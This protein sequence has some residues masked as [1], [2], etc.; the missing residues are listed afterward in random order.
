MKRRLIGGCAISVFVAL[1]MGGGCTEPPLGWPGAGRQQNLPEPANDASLGD[2]EGGIANLPGSCIPK[3]VIC[4]VDTDCCDE[5]CTDSACGGLN[6]SSTP[7]C[8]TNGVVCEDSSD[9]CDGYCGAG[10][11]GNTPS[12]VCVPEFIM[13]MT[14]AECCNTPQIKCMNGACCGDLKNCT[15]DTT[16][17]QCVPYGVT[18]DNSSEC[19]T[20]QCSLNTSLQLVCDIPP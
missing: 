5:P 15:T 14:N 17:P 10:V 1:V 7:F 8:A 13:C 3:G 19:C 16:P 11:C 18:C 9:C 6:G 12:P 4:H 2:S 20:G